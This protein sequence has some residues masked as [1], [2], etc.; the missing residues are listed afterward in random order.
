MLASCSILKLE[1]KDESSLS[2]EKVQKI[3]NFLLKLRK[4]E[5]LGGNWMKKKEGDTEKE[6]EELEG[7]EQEA[8]GMLD[9][10]L[11]GVIIPLLK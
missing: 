7:K 9:N 1:F 10:A 11:V 2:E 3:S 6:Q 5:I 4:M 8:K